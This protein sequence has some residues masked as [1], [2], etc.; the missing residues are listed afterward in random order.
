VTVTVD[1]T[2]GHKPF[3]AHQ[4]LK[5]FLNKIQFPEIYRAPAAPMD[6]PV[7][8]FPEFPLQE[9]HRRPAFD[10]RRSSC[11]MFLRFTSEQA[12]S[13]TR[14]L[15]FTGLLMACSSVLLRNKPD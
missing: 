7:L 5:F 9:S 12:K 8:H 4:F 13:K 14:N 2:A 10:F 6:W 1:Y 3:P 15:M 11:G